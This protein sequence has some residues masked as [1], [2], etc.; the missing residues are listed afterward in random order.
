M[1]ELWPDHHF[2]NVNPPPLVYR[3]VKVASLSLVHPIELFIHDTNEHAEHEHMREHHKH[4]E[5]QNYPRIL[6]PFGLKALASRVNSIIHYSKPAFGHHYFKNS[7]E[8]V[9]DIVKV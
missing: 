4:E 1:L 7:Q 2:L 3:R 5:V 8:G 6:I 9:R